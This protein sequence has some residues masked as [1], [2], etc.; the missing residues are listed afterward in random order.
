MPG[1]EELMKNTVISRLKNTN[2]WVIFFE[3]FVITQLMLIFIFNLTHLKYEAGFDSSAAMAQAMEIW[4]QKTIFLKN[5]EYQST[6]GL[7]SVIIPAS[8]FYGITH[9]IFL[10]YGIADCLGVMLYIYIFRDIFKMLKLP[11]LP[12]MIIYVL[13]LT[14]YS[15]E[16][17]GYMPMMFTGAA[18]YIIKVLIP[19][20]LIDLILKLRFNI[21]VK[22]YLHILTTYFISIY[23][24]ALSCGLYL[25]ICGL[26]PIIIYELYCTICSGSLRNIIN[27]R[28]LLLLISLIIYAAGYVSA[29]IYGASVFTN[30]MILS[31]VNNFVN[32]LSKCFVGIAELFGALPS[33]DI[34]V[35]SAFGIH[36]LSHM[37][38][39][40]IVIIIVVATIKALKPL[41]GL[42]IQSGDNKAD[43]IV[44]GQVCCIIAVN[45]AVLILT[46]TT[47]G[48]ESFEFRYHLIPVVAS[49]LI[50]GIGIDRMIKWL[51]EQKNHLIFTSVMTVIS[52]IWILNNIVF[53]YYYS[54]RNS[55]NTSEA[56]VKYVENNT[57]Y[58]KIYFLGDSDS[59]II[60]VSRIARLIESDLTIVDGPFVG[61]Y[62]G[63]GTSNKH[64]IP[65]DNIDRMVLVC[66]PTQYENIEPR[67]QYSIDILDEIDGYIIFEVPAILTDEQYEELIEE[68]EN[69]AGEDESDYIPYDSGTDSSDDGYISDTITN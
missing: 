60:E 3:L 57:D 45:L 40:I 17:L 52:I 23:L 29:K 46:D 16:P 41:S 54:S 50:I 1:N 8:I 35:T 9:N 26:F 2:P 49:F 38:A 12:R 68:I 42:I 4:N 53:V 33:K 11:K 15:L 64:F 55:Y 61:T 22:K 36:Y 20:M 63:W 69:E 66:T 65:T 27:K 67:I 19:I 21:P 62:I 13:L 58:K 18:Y 51:K 5:W 44:T 7:D 32:N 59:E 34:R 47:Y 30:E 56:I 37:A 39:F 24:T 10:A 48:S 14:P 31:S 25:L 6:L 28:S 43:K